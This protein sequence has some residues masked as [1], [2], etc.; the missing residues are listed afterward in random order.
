MLGYYRNPINHIFFNEGVIIASMNSFSDDEK[1]QKG[2]SIDELYEKS[3]FL[4]RLL[5]REQ[6]LKHDIW[7]E[8]R[9]DCFD[10]IL[11]TM[12]ERKIVVFN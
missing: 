4:S 6:V 5:K 10:K 12:I 7:K 1:W 2:V 8:K 11:Y 3:V 9:E